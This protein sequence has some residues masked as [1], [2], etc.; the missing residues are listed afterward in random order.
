MQAV[1]NPPPPPPKPPP[2][3]RAQTFVHEFTKVAP[4]AVAQ[5][6]A[7]GAVRAAGY[8]FGVAAPEVAIPAGIALGLANG[9][10]ESVKGLHSFAEEMATANKALSLYSGR[11][12]AEY[13]KLS[14]HNYQR[15]QEF[16]AATEPTALSLVRFT[17]EMRDALG[18]FRALKGNLQ[19]EAAGF[20]AGLVKGG[21]NE[22][23]GVVAAIEALR[24]ALDPGGDAAGK[25]GEIT[26]GL[27]VKALSASIFGAGVVAITEYLK[28]LPVIGKQ[29]KEAIDKANKPK[30][31]VGL[32]A[33]DAEIQRNHAGNPNR[34]APIVPDPKKRFNPAHH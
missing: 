6:G 15:N 1:V 33:W 17:D 21:A 3:S 29:I 11:L 12:T 10:K 14:I 7:G 32:G 5:T 34:L 13:V 27:I 20:G 18:P 2:P 30:D 28:S 19:N 24:L 26:A 4:Q 23:A 31:R 25:A 8:A 16:V 9:L 22:L